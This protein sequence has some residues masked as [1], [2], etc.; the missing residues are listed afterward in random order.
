MNIKN[1]FINDRMI[2]GASG[3]FSAY[4]SFGMVN[5]TQDDMDK[6]VQ[7]D[8]GY[9][10]DYPAF[11]AFCDCKELANGVYY[12]RDS[13]KVKENALTLG[14]YYSRFAL[15]NG[16]YEVYTQTSTWQ[17]ESRGG[18]QNLITGIEVS[19]RG[20]R[21]TDGATPMAVIRN[22]GNG[23][24]LVLHLMPNAA[25]KIKI[26]KA[27]MFSE[28]ASVL[29]EMG[30][31]ENGLNLVCGENE[32]V[33]MPEIIFY[34][35]EN[36][37]DFDAWKLHSAY[38]TLYP[39]RKL[40]IIY[41]T[42]MCNSDKFTPEDICRQA[43]CASELGIEMFLIDAGWFGESADWGANI[44]I[45]KENPYSGFRGRMSE[46][47]GYVRSKGLVFGLW[48]EP[49]R[50]LSRTSVAEEH[51]EYFIKGDYADL[52]L[53]F[54]NEEA[55][56]YI[57]NVVC[58]LIDKY[59]LGFLKFDFNASLSHD[60]SG[61]GFY[62]YFIGQKKFITE[63][64]ARYPELY[65]T[66]CA[67]GGTR[68]E[69]GQQKLFDSIWISDNQ[70]PIDGLRIFKDTA[71]RMPP[72]NME[73]WDVR[74]YG[75]GFPIY[76]S[77]EKTELPLSC[78]GAI[79]TSVVTV[80]ESFTH[81]F[82]SG[83][84]MGFSADIASYPNSEKKA[85]KELIKDYKADREFYRTAVMR[86]LHGTDSITVLQYSDT[87]LSRSVIHTFFKKPTQ[88]TLTVYPAVNENA[89]YLLDGE[90]IS[91]RELKENG[92]IVYIGENT[93]TV[94]DLKIISEN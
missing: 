81:A 17:N 61:C 35:T 69:L 7:R 8:S 14:S 80:S 25:W 63:L 54:S 74:L 16:D 76:Q 77:F 41:N 31:N 21:T 59:S 50:A 64:R 27:P 70:S 57:L 30:I 26:T 65:I 62:R 39:R 87:A 40:P 44:G 82:I 92:Y 45:W 75:K 72:C 19:N 47:S 60:P 58:E 38:N 90:K 36:T 23:K 56:E 15:E 73:K 43:D 52:F 79:W 89:I 4:G 29:I 78:D 51:P 22:K 68:M 24:C 71:L 20:I 33:E 91:G 28:F 2:S 13:L 32:T 11:T 46:V 66:N 94:N 88:L 10:A 3:F 37:I 9:M 49:E 34:N 86:I 67:S 42:W 18:W 12:R 55:R 5:G 84:V 83:G 6:I 85:L 1:M 48:L 53:D 93:C